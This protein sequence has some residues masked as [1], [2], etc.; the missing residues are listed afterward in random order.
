MCLPKNS[1]GLNFWDGGDTKQICAQANA[2]CVVKFEEGLFGGE[3]CEGNCE[4]LTDDWEKERADVCSS[5]G[6][7]GPS[8]N[9]VGKEGNKE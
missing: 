5:L 3:S 4:C 6:D 9:W 7:C 1:P 2:I 8:L